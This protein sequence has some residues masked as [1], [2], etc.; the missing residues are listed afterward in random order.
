MNTKTSKILGYLAVAFVI[1]Q[2]A[3][4]FYDEVNKGKS[5]R[6]IDTYTK[7][8]ITK[9]YNDCVFGG[10]AFQHYP[11]IAKANCQCLTDS[12]TSKFTKA[13]LM[14]LEK[15]SSQEKY[16]RVKEIVI[17]C[18]HKSGRDTVHVLNK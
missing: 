15:L 16:E 14:G 17:Y 4:I 2:G 1:I 11:E 13:E 7:E 3:I 8:D 6:P 5:K 9:F 18:G 10:K 12:L